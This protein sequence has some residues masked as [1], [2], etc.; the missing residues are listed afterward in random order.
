MVHDIKAP[1]DD[2]AGTTQPRV[3]HGDM[4]CSV[5]V[6]IHTGA[7]YPTVSVPIDRSALSGYP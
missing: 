5:A 1:G 6:G 4:Q 7:P 3:T 2:E